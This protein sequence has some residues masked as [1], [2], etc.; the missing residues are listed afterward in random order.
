MAK[1][2]IHFSQESLFEIFKQSEKKF[3]LNPTAKIYVT[4]NNGVLE[5]QHFAPEENV[6]ITKDEYNGHPNN[7][8]GH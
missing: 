4:D 3:G 1:T 8:D 2:T 6:S 7:K 5:T